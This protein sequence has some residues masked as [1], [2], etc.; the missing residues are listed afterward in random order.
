MKNVVVIL[1]HPGSQSFCNAVAESYAQGAQHSL[2][3]VRVLKLGELSF[4]PILNASAEVRSGQKE[5]QALEPDL[6]KA[7]QDI[8]W[9]DHLVFVYPSWWGTMPALLRGFIDRIFLPGFAFKY[10]KGKSLPDQLLKGKTAR[11]IVTMDTPS[12]WNRFIYRAAGHNAMKHAILK[13]CGIHSVRITE[14]AGMHKS[15][16]E[17]R[18]KWLTQIT[19]VAIRENP[20]DS[21]LSSF[22]RKAA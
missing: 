4:N 9:A 6:I 7:Q 3:E 17:Q 21:Q 10:Q 19:Q 18:K 12:W 5:A 13:F 22:N 14:L 2:A 11:L 20:R 16:A 1:G 15:T 8:A